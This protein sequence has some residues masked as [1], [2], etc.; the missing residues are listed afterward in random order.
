MWEQFSNHRGLTKLFNWQ[1]WNWIYLLCAHSSTTEYKWTWHLYIY[2][3]NCFQ[4]V[5]LLFYSF[6]L[7]FKNHFQNVLYLFLGNIRSFASDPVLS[8]LFKVDSNEDKLQPMAPPSHTR[9]MCA[10]RAEWLHKCLYVDNLLRNDSSLLRNDS[11]A[12]Y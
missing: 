5:V 10:L 7:S 3:I 11:K 8:D 1:N 12:K 6:I 2:D 4:I 9:C